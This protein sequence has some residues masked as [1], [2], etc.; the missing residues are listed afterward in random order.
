MFVPLYDYNPLRHLTRPYVNYAIM[1]ATVLSFFLFGGLDQAA[2]EQAAIGLGFIPAVIHDLAVL[3]PGAEIVPQGATYVTYAFMHANLLH[4]GGNLIFLWVFGDNV[5][6][7]VGHLRYLAF[8]LGCAAAGALV[9]GAVHPDSTLPL[10]GASGAVAGIVGAYLVLHPRVKLWVLLLGRIPLRLSAAWVLGAWAVFQVGNLFLAVP[11]D[12]EQ[13][14][15][16]AHI[17]GFVAGA[18]LILVLRRRA[19]PLFDRNLPDHPTR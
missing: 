18:L 9:H 5:E 2:F 11:A 17:G 6:D 4:L 7:A 10:I 19:V 8:Y 12:G 13:V 14:A 16:W 15:W 3:P 1:A